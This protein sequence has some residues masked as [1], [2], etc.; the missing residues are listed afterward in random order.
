MTGRKVTAQV[1][2]GPIDGSLITAR[3]PAVRWA[4]SETSMETFELVAMSNGAGYNGYRW[5][6]AAIAARLRGSDA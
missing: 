3:G 6:P 1:W 5:V 2:G 4:V